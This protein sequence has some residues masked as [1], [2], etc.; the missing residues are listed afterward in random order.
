MLKFR[1]SA[2]AHGITQI[3]IEE[4]LADKWGMTKWFTIHDDDEGNSPDMAVGFDAEGNGLEI[5]ISYI[6]DDEVV[7]HA[8][9]M[10]SRWQYEYDKG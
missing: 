5:G 6:E 9:I 7:F 1:S 2:F 10:T 3:Q 4:V 8:D